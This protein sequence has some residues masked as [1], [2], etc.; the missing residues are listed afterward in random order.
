MHDGILLALNIYSLSIMPGSFIVDA[1][2]DAVEIF[3]PKASE[4]DR[5]LENSQFSHFS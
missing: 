5:N 1:L 4:V 2:H 3:G